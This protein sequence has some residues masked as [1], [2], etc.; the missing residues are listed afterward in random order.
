[1]S[2]PERKVRVNSRQFLVKRLT[3]FRRGTDGVHK[4]CMSE[5]EVA[6]ILIDCHDSACGGYFLGQLTGQKIFRASFF[7]PMLFKDAHAYVK[8]CAACQQYV[9]DDLRMEPLLHVSLPL[10]PFEK[11]G[12]DNIGE[13]H[14]HSSKGM[15]YMV[16]ATELLLK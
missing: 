6:P 3:L 11:W 16:V 9:R 2:G 1:M 12:I 14:L 7:W 15:A 10:I 4:R 8:K 13:V 5:A